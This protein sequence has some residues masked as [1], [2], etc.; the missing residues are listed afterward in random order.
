MLL[1]SWATNNFYQNLVF[2]R[3]NF[4]V[5]SF[6]S[7]NVGVLRLCE[8]FFVS[9]K[10]VCWWVATFMSDIYKGNYISLCM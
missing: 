1:D 5:H 10:I 6:M 3:K 8:V 4:S 2:K 9:Y 7:L